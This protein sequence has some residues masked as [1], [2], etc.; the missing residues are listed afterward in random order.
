MQR[1]DKINDNARDGAKLTN[2]LK[3]RNNKELL[4]NECYIIDFFTI[5]SARYI[6]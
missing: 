4:L 5:N 1:R 3:S 6:P 2:K